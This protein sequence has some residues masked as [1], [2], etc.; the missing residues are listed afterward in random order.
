MYNYIDI[1]SLIEINSIIERDSKT[2]TYKYALLR[3][4]VDIIIEYPQ[5]ILP[6]DNAEFKKLPFG[7]LVFNWVFYYYPIFSSKTFIPQIRGENSNK[8]FLSIR[9]S[10][11][12]ILEFYKNRGGMEKLYNDFKKNNIPKSIKPSVLKLLKDIAKTIKSQPMKYLGKSSFDNFYS[13]A[14]FN[15]DNIKFN[16]FSF[17][18]FS[19]LL[20]FGSFSIPSK[21][22]Q[23]F[24]NLGRYISGNSSLI[25]KWT[26]FT[27]KLNGNSIQNSQLYNLLI[28]SPVTERNVGFVKD[29]LN[30]I[31]VTNK[32]N[33]VW[34][35]NIINRF[36]VDHVIPF[37]VWPNNN[38]WNLLPSA[39]DVNA[40]KLDKIPTSKKLNMSKDKI[41]F[42][43]K[44]YFDKH[45]DLFI[46]EVEYTL[47][48]KLLNKSN[49]LSDCFNALTAR[50][51]YLINQGYEP[52]N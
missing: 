5:L 29:I 52:W 35:G 42:Y 45:E 22:F 44:T 14:Y 13:F 19:D 48:G 27:L 25:A 50:C 33:C 43:W 20:K 24:E 11:H 7:L 3:G 46:E 8:P 18:G 16:N 1:N 2:S 47:T 36:A 21:Y 9:N 51:N 26:D 28:Q 4:I 10:F 40:N 39:P 30:E 38:M 17:N 23:I 37:S 49:L 31:K 41:L 34:S 12:P 15:S 6:S 32:I